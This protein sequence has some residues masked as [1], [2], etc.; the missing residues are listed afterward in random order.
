MQT[1]LGGSA[2]GAGQKPLRLTGSARYLPPPPGVVEGALA[3]QEVEG[4]TLLEPLS[5]HVT[6]AESPASVSL[7]VKSG[8]GDGGGLKP[9]FP[10]PRADPGSS[11]SPQE[12]GR[13]GNAQNPGMCR[14]PGPACSSSPRTLGKRPAGPRTLASPSPPRAPLPSS[15]FH[16]LGCK[17]HTDVGLS[18]AIRGLR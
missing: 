12:S 6:W 11:P 16:S 10:S 7:P 3:S 4:H 9:F 14:R 18:A 2:G 8:S 15:L 17:A 13:P 1:L 5:H